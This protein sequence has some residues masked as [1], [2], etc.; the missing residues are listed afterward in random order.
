MKNINVKREGKKSNIQQR[1]IRANVILILIPMLILAVIA[2]I[3]IGILGQA[4][5]QQGSDSIETQG[6][7]ALQNKLFGNTEI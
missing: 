2:F 3:Q 4:I 6:L 1:L 7:L 5:G